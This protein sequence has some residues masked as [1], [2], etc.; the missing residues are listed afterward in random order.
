MSSETQDRVQ[1]EGVSPARIL[2]VGLGFWASKTLL[3]A[4]EMEVFTLLAG[5]RLGFEELRDRVG[6]HP[7]SA[8]DFFD[9]LVALDFLE[10]RDGLYSNAPATDL[11]LDKAKPSYVGGLLEMANA[12]LFRFWADLT[13]ALRTGEVQ[14]EAK[15]GDTSFFAEL[16]ADPKW[17][18]QFATAMTGASHAVNVHLATHFPWLGY[19]TVAD[20]GAAQGDTVVQIVAANPGLTGYAFDLPP[21][22]PIVENHAA[23]CGVANCVHFVPGDFFVDDLPSADVIV[24]GHIL[25]DWD[26][27]TKRMLLAK[28]HAA[29]P[30]GGALI[31]YE[32]MIDDDRS[33]NAFGLLMSLNMLIETPGGFDYT[34]TDCAGWMR[35][36]GFRDT[37]AEPL[38]GPDT[39]VV[40]IK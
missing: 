12:R 11:F 10:R 5:R 14:N 2:E 17:L 35:G 6:V 18:G 31:V 20:I 24:M 36:A 16:Y 37:R 40:A 1:A 15:G 7:R 39:M 38:T 34:P 21:L 32:A 29:L 19:S 33:S 13:A 25:H 28:A 3:S 23:R 22:A 9:A 27:E 4:V 26:L 8:R 30:E